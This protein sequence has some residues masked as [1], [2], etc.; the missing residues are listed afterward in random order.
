MN[1]R[2]REEI[3]KTIREKF[4]INEDIKHADYH[5]CYGHQEYLRKLTV[6]QSKGI[7]P[8]C[9]VALTGS[10]KFYG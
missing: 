10:K 1:N 7:C 4:W 8:F 6:E 3:E 5:G 9:G 2:S